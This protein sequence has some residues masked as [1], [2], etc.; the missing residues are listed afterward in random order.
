MGAFGGRDTWGK[1]TD[2][3]GADTGPAGR[4]V[5][6][7]PGR[8][9]GSAPA[10]FLEPSPCG[11]V[12]ALCTAVLTDSV[13]W[14]GSLGGRG[15]RVTYPALKTWC[16]CSVSPWKACEE[17][18]GVSI[19]VV[20]SFAERTPFHPQGGGC[21]DSVEIR[22]EGPRAPPPLPVLPEGRKRAVVN[23]N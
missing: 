14:A 10:S 20:P 23:T 4:S 6:S 18:E 19:L 3:E 2:G 15:D 22:E 7:C 21:G 16:P 12:C 13:I 8:G 9:L 5:C 1:Q 11:L 17:G